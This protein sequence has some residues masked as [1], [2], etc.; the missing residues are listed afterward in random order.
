MSTLYQK[1]LDNQTYINNQGE[2]VN[3]SLTKIKLLIE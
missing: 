3:E 2:N 1:L